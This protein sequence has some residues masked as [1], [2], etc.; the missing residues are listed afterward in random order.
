MLDKI[1]F[2]RR[3]FIK[4]TAI[5]GAALSLPW[6]LTKSAYAANASPYLRKWIQ[7]L[8]GLGP[9]GIPLLTS[10]PDPVFPNTNFYNVI[11]GEFQDTLHP[12][13]GGPTTLWGYWDGAVSNPVKHHLGGLIIAQRGTASRLRFT[14]TLPPDPI[15]PADSSNFFPDAASHKNKIAIHLHGGFIPWICDGGPY[16]WFT[17]EGVSGPSFINGP[18]GVLDNILRNR[19][20]PGQ[21]D[22][23]YP[24]DQSCRLMW[25]HDHAHDL[26]RT[27]AYAGLATGYLVLDGINNMYVNAGL[28]PGLASTIPLIFQDKTFVGPNTATT[29]PTW[30]SIM[31]PGV[32][33]NGS[34]RYEHLYNPADLQIPDGLPLPDPSCVPEFFGDTMLANGTVYPYCEVQ[35]KR[36]RFLLLNACN[37]RVM[38]LNLFKA[39]PGNPDGI[40]LNEA[41]TFPTNPPGPNMIQIGTEAGFLAREAVFVSP[42]PFIAPDPNTLLPPPSGNLFLAP[43]ERADLIIDFS[44]Y[45]VGDEFILYND[46]AAPFPFGDPANDYYLGNPDPG[47]LVQPQPGTGPD[48]RQV[49]RIKVVASANDPQ[50]AGPILDPMLMDPAPLVNVADVANIAYNDPNTP[51]PP[52]PVPIGATVRQLTLNEGWDAWGRL[53]QTLGTTQPTTGTNGAGYGMALEDPP[54]EGYLQSGA[55]EVWQ[56]FNLTGDTHPIHFHLINL[57]ILSRA[58]FDY[59]TPTFAPITGTERGPDRNELGWKETVRINPGEVITVIAKFD[60]PALPFQQPSSPRM[61][62]IAVSPNPGALAGVEGPYNEYV[63]HCHILEHEEHDMMRP[64]VTA[65]QPF[66]VTQVQEVTVPTRGSPQTVTFF[67]SGGKFPYLVTNVKVTSPPTPRKIRFP[68]LGAGLLPVPTLRG[69]DVVVTTRTKPGIYEF[70]VQDNSRPRNIATAILRVWPA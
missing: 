59:M 19:M 55:T 25:Y 50:P 39:N 1:K 30:F 45:N 35:A 3:D 6:T 31:K 65:G 7:A 13:L 63:Y 60:L 56:L 68:L 21:A 66:E 42:K 61:D 5:V 47:Q 53:I 48:T 27:N 38:N 43:A 58:S 52:L 49:L 67:V 54:T 23:F 51:V 64:L 62:T 34:L 70:T 14:N 29:D 57:Q 10:V 8:R 4:R 37:A 22:Y 36:Y 9:T 44:G 16:D 12:D 46:A 40:D 69:F 20:K 17:P 32:Q 28:I 18:R 33:T 2:S 26:T 24:N 15:I 11:A 41:G